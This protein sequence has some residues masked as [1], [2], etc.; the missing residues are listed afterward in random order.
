MPADSNI[1]LEIFGY[2]GTALVIISMLMT[3]VVK[4]RIFNICGAVISLI[5]AALVGAYPVVV[6]NGALTTINTVQLIRIKFK[7]TSSNNN[8]QNDGAAE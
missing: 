4:L 8:E 2:I 3:S 1:Y 7:K 5:Y 6:L